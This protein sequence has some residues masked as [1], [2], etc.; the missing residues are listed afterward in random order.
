MKVNSRSHPLF[1]ESIPLVKNLKEG[2]RVNFD[3]SASS[4][5]S[6]NIIVVSALHLPKNAVFDSDTGAF[7]WTAVKGED[8]L[9]VQAHDK[10]Y[11]LK[12]NHDITFIVSGTGS[13]NRLHQMNFLV[14]FVGLIVL[15]C[16]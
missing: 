16:Q 13:N 15:L 4:E 9:S 5:Y 2:D 8:Y 6:S 1:D 7:K 3:M 12:T 10:T 14:L 11:N